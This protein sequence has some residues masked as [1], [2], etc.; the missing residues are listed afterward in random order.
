MR[1][2]RKAS[3]SRCPFSEEKPADSEGGSFRPAGDGLGGTGVQRP[4]GASSGGVPITE[5]PRRLARGA[6]RREQ[7]AG[8][9][10]GVL[11]ATRRTGARVSLHTCVR[12]AAHVPPGS[13]RNPRKR[14]KKRSPLCT[15]PAPSC[16]HPP[17]TALHDR[18]DFLFPANLSPSP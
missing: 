1:L 16:H 12:V 6:R 3:Q 18:G 9:P 15:L 4:C 8:H 5:K 7:G 2:S 14:K 13:P 11:E 10:T 17:P